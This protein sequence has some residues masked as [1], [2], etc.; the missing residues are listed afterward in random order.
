MSSLVP[1]MLVKSASSENAS[2][3]PSSLKVSL[4][5]MEGESILNLGMKSWISFDGRDF[6]FARVLALMSFIVAPS[7]WFFWGSMMRSWKLLGLLYGM[8]MSS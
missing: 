7:S 3:M 1:N 8:V 6:A 4:R 5:S 2:D